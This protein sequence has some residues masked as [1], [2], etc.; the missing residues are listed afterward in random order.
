MKN[1]IF[2][3]VANE[4]HFVCLT[5]DP[6]KEGNLTVEEQVRSKDQLIAVI[7]NFMGA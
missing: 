1:F 3:N 5:A 4:E 7:S 2:A 6:N